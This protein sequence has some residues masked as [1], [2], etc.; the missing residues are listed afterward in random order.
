MRKS[1]PFRKTKNGHEASGLR[2]GKKPWVGRY[3]RIELAFLVNLL[4]WRM[5]EIIDLVS[6]DEQ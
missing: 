1:C 3:I 4:P 6:D 2:S 5:P